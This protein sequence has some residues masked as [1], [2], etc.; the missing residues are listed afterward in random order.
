MDTALT[1]VALIAYFGVAG[2]AAYISKA[3]RNGPNYHPALKL[4]ST[5]TGMQGLWVGLLFAFFVITHKTPP[6]IPTLFGYALV[7]TVS[8]VLQFAALR[9]VIL[10]NRRIGRR[11][12]EITG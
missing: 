2:M 7:F 1:V 9:L 12:K 5:A 10:R 4:T 8:L 11:V 3:A 6:H